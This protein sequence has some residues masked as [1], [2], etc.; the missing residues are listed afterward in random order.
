MARQI[1]HVDMDEFFAAVEKLDR[2]E[3]VGKCL[4]IGGE[5]SRRGVVATAS[6]E[7]RKFGCNSAMPMAAAIRRC[8]QA[9]VLP[10]R[11]QRYRQ[12]SEQVFGI[13]ERFTPQIEPLSIDEAFLDMTGTE[14]LFGPA[15][16][17]AR[18][19]KQTVRN[20][21]GLVCSVGLAPNK[22]LA[23]LASDLEK[24][25]GL[26]VITQE[27]LHAKLDPLPIRK[28][29]GVGPAGETQLH[30]YNIR[31]IGQLRSAPAE[32]V[33]QAFGEMGEHF[34]RLASGLDSRRVTPD[35]RAKSI[36]QEQTFAVDVDD[37]EEL[38]RLMRQQV[39]Q[40]AR[41]LR[42]NGLAARTVTI[43][44][45]YGDFTTIT[46]SITLDR[47]TD[48]T[49][50]I[51]QAATGLFDLWVQHS[52]RPLRLLGVTTSQMTKAGTGQLALFETDQHRK[53]KK[54]DRTLDTIVERFGDSAVSR[55]LTRKNAP[56][57]RKGGDDAS[58]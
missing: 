33:R 25:D 17:T 5:A 50:E 29:W 58:R 46:R 41:R 45:R 3:L 8:P 11:G 32:M 53:R 18:R 27:N 39:E 15:I 7:A 51:R 21:L 30:K 1:L 44:L 37:R 10:V 6:Y 13:F 14:R 56:K 19:L 20:E 43:K 26:T 36:G 4:L 2:P 35:S 24:P 12:I 34:Q 49:D 48:V 9:I 42:R 28:L 16:E 40:V 47:P 38:C 31:T 54:L 55:G 57:P 22:F 23:K 52:F